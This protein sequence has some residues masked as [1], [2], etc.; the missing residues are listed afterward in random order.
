MQVGNWGSHLINC[1]RSE[2]MYCHGCKWQK[3]KRL[4]SGKTMNLV[5]WLT[6]LWGGRESA[7]VRK[8]W[9]PLWRPP[10][11][12]L[13]LWRVSLISQTSFLSSWDSG[14][15][16][17]QASH[18]I[19]LLSDGDQSLLL[20]AL[21]LAASTEAVWFDGGKEQPPKRRGWPLSTEED[22]VSEPQI[23]L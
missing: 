1:W 8:E 19:A 12:S 11:S 17:A 15:P 21:W 16:M 23:P 14:Q 10:G 13:R 3:P 18:L 9:K 20:M 6:K 5:V 4:S 7:G 2:T 22:K